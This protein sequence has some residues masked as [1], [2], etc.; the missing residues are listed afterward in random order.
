MKS[1][2]RAK[3]LKTQGE[4][5]LNPLIEYKRAARLAAA[6]RASAPALVARARPP[7]FAPERAEVASLMYFF[8]YAQG[9]VQ[10]LLAARQLQQ[11]GWQF[12]T[13]YNTWF[14]RLGAPAASSPESETG[15]FAYF[16]F[17]VHEGAPGWVVRVREDFKFEYRHLVSSS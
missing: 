8:Y 16:D 10:Q 17:H 11:R 15:K 2:A 13:Q 12:H 3:S 1:D 6:G 4:I 7:A 9:T 5:A 14:R